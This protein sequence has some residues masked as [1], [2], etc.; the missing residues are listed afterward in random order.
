V[1][2]FS[3]AVLAGCVVSSGDPPPP[4]PT[5]LPAEGTL[6]I[7]WSIN[8]ST[9]PNQC[10]QSS[11]VSIEITVFASADDSGSTFAD[12]CNAFITSIPLARGDYAA[13]AVLVDVN[14]NP[15]TTVLDIDPFRILGEDELDIPIDFPANSFL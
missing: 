7:D 6:T 12:A 9:D 14:D 11:A 13:S 4:P 1:S 15:R 3:S 10:N 5:S 2:L 8:G